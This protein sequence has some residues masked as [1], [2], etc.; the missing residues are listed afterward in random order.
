VRI[1]WVRANTGAMTAQGT[2]AAP[3]IAPQDRA[4]GEPR[5]WRDRLGIAASSLCAVHCIGTAVVLALAP[6]VS[7]GFAADE[8]LE[9]AA[10]GFA[11][12]VGV[13]ALVPAF[14]S[15]HR[16]LSPILLFVMGCVVVLLA[17]LMAPEEGPWELVGAVLGAALMVSGH[18][19]N[20]RLAKKC[21][22]GCE[23]DCR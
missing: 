23:V 18:V 22:R 17:R 12:L 5:A 9:W 6:T 14:R 10:F 11:I 16:K 19:T 21:I 3:M 20:L 8:R 13:G 2:Q 15:M 4:I 1:Q 7:L